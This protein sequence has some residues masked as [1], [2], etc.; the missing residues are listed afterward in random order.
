MEQNINVTLSDEEQPAAQ[1]IIGQKLDEYNERI[2]GKIH[3][4]A[5]NIIISDPHTGE[6]LGGLTGR[7][8]LGVLFVDLM[9]VPS[10]FRSIGLGSRVLRQAEAE[11]KRRGC[12]QAF[13]YT[14]S[15]QAPEFY[16]KHGYT[17]F[18]S[19]PCL[20][21]GSSRIFLSKLL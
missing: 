5:L 19:I 2:T 3:S 17:V 6:V 8:S 20:P 1:N 12:C 16:E 9:F 14:I 13:V 21:E 11:A 4:Q 10:D 18:G 7:T 15:F